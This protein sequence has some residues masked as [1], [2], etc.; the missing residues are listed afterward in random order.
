[1]PPLSKLEHALDA[2]ARGFPIVLRSRDGLLVGVAVVDHADE[3]LARER[4]CLRADGYAVRMGADGR[5]LRL[6]RVVAGCAPGDGVVV[7]HKNGL[8]LDCRRDN[9]RRGTQA[10]NSQ[11]RTDNPYRGVGW[12]KAARK[13]RARVKLDYVEHHLGLFDTR[14][15]ALHAAAAFRAAH[16]PYSQEAAA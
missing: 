2:A 7:D 16:M 11:N 12:H 6:H 1:M 14:D 10:L 3:H 13:W 15:A 4:W 8:R 9:L 5:M